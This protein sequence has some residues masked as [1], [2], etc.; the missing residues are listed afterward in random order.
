MDSQCQE[1]GSQSAL[2]SMT[3][4]VHEEDNLTAPKKSI[5]NEERSSLIS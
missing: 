2:L 5:D 4:I 1:N 3:K